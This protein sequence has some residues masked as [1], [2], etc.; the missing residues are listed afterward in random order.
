MT[1]DEKL[2]SITNKLTEKKVAEEVIKT[3]YK[4][5][6]KNKAL[7]TAQRLSRIEE[8]IGL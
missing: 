4:D 6:E 5:L 7:T 2:I 1:T 8:F 3:N